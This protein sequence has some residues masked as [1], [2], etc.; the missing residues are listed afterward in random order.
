[1]KKINK[2][3]IAVLLV[4]AMTVPTFAATK[5]YG[6]YNYKYW[7]EYSKKYYDAWK[8]YKNTWSNK[9]PELNKDFVTQP[10]L[11]EEKPVEEEI[12]LEAPTITEAGY[13][14]Q[15]PYYGMHPELIIRWNKVENAKSYEIQITKADGTILNY[16]E[17]T[18]SLIDRGECPKVYIEETHTWTAAEVKV[19]AVGDNDVKSE[20]S[21]PDKIGCDILHFK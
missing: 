3:I 8:N 6:N 9:F 13:K 15:C 4:F 10:E 21:E 1:M 7:Q 12:I 17:D 16:T 14:H 19:R 2:L 11:E 5:T 20:W 18:T